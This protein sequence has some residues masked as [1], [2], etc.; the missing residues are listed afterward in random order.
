[1]VGIKVGRTCSGRAVDVIAGVEVLAGRGVIVAAAVAVSDGIG[2][3]VGVIDCPQAISSM[4]IPRKIFVLMNIFISP[5]F[6]TCACLIH[7][8]V[9]KT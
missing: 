6:L 7:L 8:F 3:A 9:S 2:D 5:T 1:M 4:Q